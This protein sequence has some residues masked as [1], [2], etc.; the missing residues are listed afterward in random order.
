MCPA[1]GVMKKDFIPLDS[2]YNPEHFEDHELE[3]ELK[4]KIFLTKNVVELKFYC[5]KN[6]EI[7]S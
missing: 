3:F 1:C 4:S 5:E 7:I 2:H 6:L